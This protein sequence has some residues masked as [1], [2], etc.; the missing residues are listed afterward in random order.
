VWLSLTLAACT[1]VPTP[2]PVL[3][4]PL[5]TAVETPP[6][7]G[8]ATA[9]AHTWTVLSD[10]V[11]SETDLV[12]ATVLVA[13]RA[14]VGQSALVDISSLKPGRYQVVCAIPGHFSAGMVGELVIGA[15]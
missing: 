13:G 1:T 12:A 4:E 7:V 3:P 8:C 9:V 15:D 5:S 10:P 6:L 14:D 2:P 11:E